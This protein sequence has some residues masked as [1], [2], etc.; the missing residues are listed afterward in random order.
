VARR[1]WYLLLHQ[2]RGQLHNLASI[3]I[4]SLWA[5]AEG[6]LPD[7]RWV[8]LFIRWS[9]TLRG[10]LCSPEIRKPWPPR[11]VH[12]LSDFMEHQSFLISGVHIS[13]P[14]PQFCRDWLVFRYPG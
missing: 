7:R 9:Y 6:D 3:F 13:R 10:R 14:L 4:F 12:G 2:Y 1:L 5:E 11:G 8:V